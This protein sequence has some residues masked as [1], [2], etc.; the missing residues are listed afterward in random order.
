MDVHHYHL[1]IHYHIY[2][3]ILNKIKIKEHISSELQLLFLNGN[4]LEDNKTNKDYNIQNM[5]TL[6]LVLKNK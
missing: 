2:L 5:S 1:K 3:K 4:Q 6:P